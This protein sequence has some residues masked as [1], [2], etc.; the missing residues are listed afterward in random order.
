MI[1][2]TAKS[3]DKKKYYENWLKEHGLPFGRCPYGPEEGY[4]GTSNCA[5]YAH[6][7]TEFREF[8]CLCAAGNTVNGPVNKLEVE[9]CDYKRLKD[10]HEK[11][12][13]S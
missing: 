11:Q 6:V 7:D 12:C 5:M 4:V 1:M 9:P 2:E 8:T 10:L 13:S 3:E